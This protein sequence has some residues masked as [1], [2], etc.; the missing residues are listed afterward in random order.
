ML[1]IEGYLSKIIFHNKENNYYILSIF[2]NEDYEDI[3]SDYVIVV[4]T[5]KDI[6]LKD[7]ELYSF[8]G[9]FVEHKKYGKQFSA[10][11]IEQII[12]K[13]KEAIIT[14]LSGAEFHGIGKKTAE[15]IVEKLGLDC[16]EKIYND[17]NELYK[18]KEISE[19]RKEIIYNNI[20]SNQQS[21]NIILKLNEYNISNN[22]ITKIYNF[23]KNK[24]LD[25]IK[26]NPYELIDTMQGINFYTVDKIA[27]KVGI[28]FDDRNR[29]SSAFIYTLYNYCF[30]TGNTYI[31]KNNLLYLTFNTLYKARNTPINK[32]KILEVLDYCLEINKIIEYDNLIFLPEIFYSES[33]IYN[34]ISQRIKDNEEK[35]ISDS[36]LEK[37]IDDIEKELKIEYDIEQI[38]AIKN[39]INKNFSIITGGPGTGKT[40]II[41]GIIKL[42]QKI[43]NYSYNDILDEE[44]KIISLL[45][46]TGKAAKRMSET[47]G[48]FASTI[49]KAIGWTTEDEKINEFASDKKIDSKLIIIDEASMIDIFLMHN[50]LKIIKKDALIILVG[51]NDQL[52]SIAP[53]NILNDLINSNSIPT[54]KLNK[55]FRQA[56]NSSIIK[57]SYA[58]KNN[59]NLDITEEFEDKEFIITKKNKILDTIKNIYSNLLNITSRNN[60]QILAPIY[61]TNYGINIINK[62]IQDEFN[63]NDTLIEYGENIYKIDDRIMQLVNRPEDNIFNGDIGVVYDIYKEDNK[64]KIVI[65]YDGNYVTYEKQDLNQICLSYASSIHKSQGSE[66][67]YVIIP[68]VDSYNFMFNKNLIYTA[69]TRAKTKLIFCGEKDVF[70]KASE[71]N[72]IVKRDTYLKEF[73]VKKEDCQDNI[74]E[75][76]YILTPDN[77]NNIDA[78]IGMD[79]ITPLDYMN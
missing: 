19:K 50:L 15:I 10:I 44:K 56:E 42:F 41:L 76:D 43:H 36:L 32:E 68:L 3:D 8:K 17:K 40:T 45:A 48:L 79:N 59:I 74:S 49:H 60:I 71:E 25:I 51:D 61:K 18:I 23:Y 22:L 57:L 62:L 38:A 27:E 58:I 1:T 9:N 52:P 21:Q 53:G 75:I 20:I 73:F 28:D 78:M 26:N 6:D 11:T 72:N 64:F 24:T 34:N 47:T 63:N 13:N 30:S 2:L 66:F 35:K 14:Y 65:E 31:K 70:Y 33:F 16:L 39:S 7:E 46:P 55:I 12:Q 54:V 69:I 67:D 5:F 37:Y 4:G 29:I 77:I